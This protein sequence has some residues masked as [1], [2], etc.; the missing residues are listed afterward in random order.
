MAKQKK[1]FCP[2]NHDTFA[3]GRNKQGKCKICDIER[4]KERRKALP[5]PKGHDKNIVGR[6]EDG[7][8]LKCREDR[9]VKKQQHVLR[10]YNKQ[11]FCKRGHEIAVVGRYPSGGCI[12]CSKDRD[13]TKI[14][15]RMR[16]KQ[17]CSNGHNTFV[18]G[19]E[20]NGSCKQCV[21]EKRNLPENKEKAS[22]LSKKHYEEH[23]AE[24]L[25]RHKQY[26]LEH[27]EDYA[28]NT[29]RWRKENPELNILIKLEQDSLRGLRTVPWGQEGMDEF[30]KNKPEGMTGDHIIPLQGEA[31]SGL[32]VRWNLQYLSLPENSSKGNKCDLMEATRF[33]EK[34]LIEA[35]LK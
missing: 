21:K 34:I 30:Y 11:K 5:C 24:I 31:V 22:Q 19:R 18:I 23:K 3:T 29:A 1:Q 15:E 35:G 27:H 6:A 20:K 14:L 25:A 12:Q 26:A 8:C 33:Y 13:V 17:F 16:L 32:H 28:I 10:I 7:Y 9:A 4:C 2:K